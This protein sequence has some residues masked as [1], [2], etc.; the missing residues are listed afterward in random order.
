MGGSEVRVPESLNV[1][2]SDFAFMGGN[3]AKVGDF[4][5]DPGGPTVRIRLIAIM[6]GNDVKRGRKLSRAE[7]RQQ[8]HLRH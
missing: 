5:P 3:D 4:T 7:R 6:G 1:E 2:V 8:K